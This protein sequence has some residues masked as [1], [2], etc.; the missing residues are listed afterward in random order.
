MAIRLSLG[1]KTTRVL[2][3][4]LLES[5]LMS[6]AGATA[7]L[8]LAVVAE[9]LLV[10]AFQWQDR[11]LDLSMDARMLGFAAA[12]SL[13][14]TI[15]F[16]LAPALR[17]WRGGRLAL[18]SERGLTP[19]FG[20]GKFLVMVEVAL[21]LVLLAGAAVF[22]RSFQNLRAVPTGFSTQR[23]SYVELGN[24]TEPDS[25]KAPYGEGTLLVETL[26]H[27]PGVEAAGL[28]DMLPF[29]EGWIGYDVILPGITGRQARRVHLLRVDGGYFATLRISLQA[30]RTFTPRD[31]LG[32]PKVAILTEGTA[33]RLFRGENPIGKHILLGAPPQPK[34]ED[35]T[36]IV[37]IVNDIKFG[38]VTAPAPN[39][40]FQSLLQGQ[41]NSATTSTLKLHVRSRMTPAEVA[42][43][44][45]SRIGEM[46]LPVSV[47]RAA[48]LEDAIAHSM[49]NDRI[50]MQAS[51]VFGVLALLLITAGIYGLMAYSVAMRTREIGIRIAVGSR[52]G[53]I[54]AMV[55]RQGLRLTMAGV[56]LGIPCAMA[57]MKAVSKLVF[58][59]APFDWASIA[60]AALTLCATGIL[61]S[62]APAWRAAHLDP[63]KA[64]RVE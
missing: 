30:G 33:R 56:T 38:S 57:V 58:G 60:F 26:R 4:L 24:P 1:G 61:A 15:L 32:A 46:G 6:L 2:R 63:V 27:A 44:A 17:V 47:D 25:L 16:G 3:Q 55:L 12:L 52:P 42:T 9:R 28:S 50:R 36:E 23:V 54:V 19:R 14:T 8:A 41:H 53:E 37:G 22:L 20:A 11:P 10:A 45:R 5:G 49:L 34:P 43:L 7:G 13:V 51:G 40:V 29:D 62:L 18:H 39:L 31:D 59:L 64:L 21:S 35:E 48:P